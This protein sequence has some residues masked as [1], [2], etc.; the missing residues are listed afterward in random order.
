MLTIKPLNEETLDDYLEFFDHVAF[1]DNPEWAGCYC[2]FNHFGKNEL[3][4]FTATGYDDNYT[5]RKASEYVKEGILKGYLAYEASEVVGWLSSNQ[6]R[7]YVR[8]FADVD[9]TTSDDDYIKSVACFTISPKH[10]QKGIATALLKHAEQQAKSEGYQYIEAYPDTGHTDCYMNY[11]GF[12]LMFE[13][14]GFNTYKT[15]DKCAIMRKDL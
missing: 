10:R 3:D 2:T 6:K 7:Q 1:S 8:L 12:K 15:L 13:K 5:R 11:H 4:E 9:V 14:H